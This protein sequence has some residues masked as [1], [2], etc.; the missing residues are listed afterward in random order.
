MIK[1]IV[2]SFF[3][4]VLLLGTGY[5]ALGWGVW[6]HQHINRAAVFALPA[7]MRTFYFNHIDYLTME[8]SVPDLRKYVL[9]DR[10]EFP[11]HYIDVEV[12]GTDPF[13]ALPMQWD[14]AVKKYGKDKLY[15]N[16]ILPWYLQLM[17]AKLTDAFKEK[18]KAKILFISATLAHYV[19]DGYQPLHTTTNYDGQLSG[20]KGV[21]SFFESLLPEMFGRTYNL[22]CSPAAYYNDIPAAAWQIVKQ[23][24][25]LLP[26]LLK[27]EKQLL[28]SWPESKLYELDAK[29]HIKKN[30]YNQ[31]W[32]SRAFATAFH[33]NLKGMVAGQLQRA[34]QTTASFWY[35]AWVNAGK[36]DLSVLD[37]DYTRK[38]NRGPLRAQYQLWQ[39]TGHL[40]GIQ[41]T[42]EF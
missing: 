6:G 12:Y 21:H 40:Q 25:A 13:A 26:D 3:G 27:A 36:P 29:G 22:H 35:T 16:G 38:I 15:K 11:R 37:D 2:A 10:N 20:Q 23:S 18:D 41:S 19:G 34:I 32:Y 8:A 17:T 24:H 4:V 14:E 30:R 7:P 31:P 1:K 5:V 33:N 42:A 28:D 9:S 39:G